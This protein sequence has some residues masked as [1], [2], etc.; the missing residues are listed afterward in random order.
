MPTAPNLPTVCSE[1]DCGRVIL[2]RGLCNRH[3]LRA[4]RAGRFPPLRTP[5]DR[6]WP[7]VDQSGGPDA[8]WPWLGS[9]AGKQQVY[10]KVRSRD[11][12]ILAHRQ[13]WILT[14][15]PIP[16]KLIV[17]HTCDNPPC[18]NPK[19]LLLGTHVD[20]A[21]DMLDRDR[22]RPAHP[23]LDLIDVVRIRQ[24]LAD[25]FIQRIIAERFGIHQ[26]T[27]SEI[28]LGKKWRSEA[29]LVKH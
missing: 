20:N 28:K 24:M 27:V 23:K 10:G 13:A 8:C 2:A 18:C 19:H 15:G 21:Y 14:Y 3:Y 7:W 5:T 25:G 26:A 12:S 22:C 17:R 6:F 9:K 1:T 29:Y 4:K 11:Q 16:E